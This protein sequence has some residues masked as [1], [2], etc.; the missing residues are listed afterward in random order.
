MFLAKLF[1]KDIYLNYIFLWLYLD[2]W[3]QLFHILPFILSNY[4]IQKLDL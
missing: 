4:F 1:L 2:N 3:V